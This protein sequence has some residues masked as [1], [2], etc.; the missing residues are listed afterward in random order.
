MIGGGTGPPRPC[1]GRARVM[2]GKESS[3]RRWR[4]PGMDASCVRLHTGRT[5]V[6]L[7]DPNQQGPRPILSTDSPFARTVACRSSFRTKAN[8][9]K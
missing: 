3:R 1:N 2:F 6:E 5:G 9:P 4:R 7:E 8:S